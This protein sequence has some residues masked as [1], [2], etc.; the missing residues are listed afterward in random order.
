MSLHVGE[1]L[2]AHD[3][4]H[5]EHARVASVGGDRHSKVSASATN[6]P[7]AT[8]A[9]QAS[10]SFSGSRSDL[11]KTLLL[12]N[13]ENRSGRISMPLVTLLV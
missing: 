11:E 8:R 10:G 3:I 5:E 7:S 13:R 6:T 4:G 2:V 12:L 1:Q 9:R